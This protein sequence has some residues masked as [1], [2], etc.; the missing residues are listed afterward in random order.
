MREDDESDRPVDV[1]AVQAFRSRVQGLASPDGEFVVACRET[2][3]RPAPVTGSRFESYTDAEAARDAAHRYRAAMRSL[4]PELARY[5]LAVCERG[6]DGVEFASVREGTDGT[7]TNGLP[8]SR[9][10][11]TLT[12]D[13]TDE[14]IRVENA[15]LVHL[16]GPDSPLD[17][18]IVERQIGVQLDR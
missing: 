11:A 18:E 12:G 2:G 4:D 16:H 6:S 13:R 15:P 10:T 5:D 1:E 3:V 8:R 14:W 9:Q 17:D 7:R